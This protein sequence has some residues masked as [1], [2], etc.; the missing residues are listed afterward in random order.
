M[1]NFILYLIFSFVVSSSFS[2]TILFTE[3]FEN[4]PGSVQSSGTPGWATNSRLHVSGLNCDSSFVDTVGSVSYLQTNSFDCTGLFYVALSF[5]NICKV[6]FFD[7]GIIE[8]SIDG[9][10]TWVQLKDNNGNPGN[11]NNC[12][13][14]G[15]GY[16]RTQGSKFQEASYANWMA[17]V[18]TSPL[19]SWW[20]TE[21]FDIS[22]VAANQPD[23]KLRFKLEDM[24]GTGGNNRSGWYIDDIQIDAAICEPFPPIVNASFV[25]DKN[26]TCSAPATIQFTDLS[27]NAYSLLWDF[28]DG[29]FSIDSNPLH[30][31]ADTGTYTVTLIAIGPNLCSPSDTLVMTDYI[32][33]TNLGEPVAANCAPTTLNY[34]CNFGIN[35]FSFGSIINTSSGGING[36]QNYTCTFQTTAIAGSAVPIEIRTNATAAENVHVWI[37][38]NGDGD[39]SPDELVFSSLYTVA[40]H[41]GYVNTDPNV[42]LNTPLRMRVMSDESTIAIVNSCTP[43][44]KGEVEDYTIT[45]YENLNS[46]IANF[47]SNDTLVITGSTIHFQ[48]ISDHAPTSWTWSFPGG[49]PSTSN[50]QNPDIVYNSTGIFPVSL[51]VSNIFGIDSITKTAYIHVVNSINLCSGISHTNAPA[52]KLFDSGGIAGNYQNNENC[53]FL[54]DVD[55]ATSVTLTFNS[56]NLVSGDAIK[57]YSGLNSSGTLLLT[58]SGNQVPAP[59]TVPGKSLF[60]NFTSNSASVAF[61]FDINWTAAVGSSNPTI[62]SFSIDNSNPP[63]GVQVNFTDN[64]TNDP[65]SWQWDFG[66]GTFSNLQNPQHAFFTSGLQNIKLVA[67]NCFSTDT[68]IQTLLVQQAPVITAT[69]DSAFLTLGCG[70]TG[71]TQLTITNSGAG[72]LIIE[73]DSSKVNAIYDPVKILALNYGVSASVY[74][75]LIYELNQHFQNYSIEVTTTDSLQ[76]LQNALVDKDILILPPFNNGTTQVFTTLSPAILNFANNGGFVISCGTSSIAPI[77]NTG[78]FTLSSLINL[79]GN[80]LTVNQS[81]HPLADSVSSFIAPSPT[82]G[83]SGINNDFNNVL[84]YQ[85][86][87]IAGFRDFGLGKAIYTG[88]ANF[89][90]SSSQVFANA[91]RWSAKHIKNSIVQPDVFYD[92]LSFNQ[93][94]SINFNI[95]ATKLNAGVHTFPVTIKNNDPAQQNLVV[96]IVLTVTGLP[97]MILSDTCVNFGSHQLYI[98]FTDS[99]LISNMGCDTLNITSIYSSLP[100]FTSS[101]SSLNV[102]PYD[103]VWLHVTF[104]PDSN[105][106]FNGTLTLIN[107][108]QDT[109]ICLTGAGLVGPQMEF[110]PD[111]IFAS[112]VCGGQITVPFTIYNSG[113]LPLNFEINGSDTVDVLAL[114]YGVD[115]AN[116]YTNTFN[117]INQ[118]FTRYNRT[119]INT[120]SPTALQTALVGKE[121]F[122]LAEPESGTTSVF[123]TFAPVLQ[124]FVNN[125]GT[126]IL[127]GATSS[128]IAC[129]FNTGLLSGNYGGSIGGGQLNVSPITHLITD[130]IPPVFS[131]T[132]NTYS[133]AI[134]S[135]G[136]NQLISSLANNAVVGHVNYGLGQVIYNGF[137]YTLTNSSSVKLAGNIM[138]FAAKK[139]FGPGISV[140]PLIDTISSTD[141]TII[142]VTFDSNFFTAGSYSGYIN[143]FSNHYSGSL[144]SIPYV[145]TVTG[146]PNISLG[147]TCLNYGTTYIN[148]SVTDSVL[149]Y[150]TGCDSLVID[151]LLTS[152]PFSTQQLPFAIAPYD[153]AWIHVSSLT[154][155]AGVFNSTLT[156][157][158]NVTD[159]SICLNVT[160]TIPPTLASNTDTI[161]V[162]LGCS[163]IVDIPIT[164]YNTG[165]NPLIINSGK[166]P[167]RILAYTYGVDTINEY[168]NTLNSLNSFFDD[169]TLTETNTITPSVLQ[170]YLDD[171]DVLLF[172]KFEAGGGMVHLTLSNTITTNIASGKSA[173]FC[174]STYSNALSWFNTGLI[175]GTYLGIISNST[176]LTVNMNHPIA[177]GTTS[178]FYPINSTVSLD[179]V[180]PFVTDVMSAGTSN[181]VSTWPFGSGQVVYSG[182]DFTSTSTNTS[183]VISNSMKWL[184]QLKFK[185]SVSFTIENDTILPG[186]SLVYILSINSDSLAGGIHTANL[187]ISSNDPVTPNFNIPIVMHVTELPCSDFTYTFSSCNSTAIFFPESKN[188]ITSLVWSFGDG[189]TTSLAIPGYSYANSGTYLVSLVAC[190]SFGCDS[191]TK[192]I[193]IL[194]DPISQNCSPQTINTCCGMG[195]VNFSFS[196]INNI[197]QNAVAGYEKFTCLNA[198]QLTAGQTYPISIINGSSTNENVFAWIDYDNDGAFSSAEL[199]FTGLNNTYH[200]GLITIPNSP[201]LNTNL[202]MRIGSDNAN[203]P[204][205]SPCT[206]SQQGQFED[207]KVIIYPFASPVAQFSYSYIDTCDRIIEFTDSSSNGPTSWFWNFG[208]GTFATTQ[209]VQH[210]YSQP[211]M[212]NVM[213]VVTNSA[214]SNSITIPISVNELIA[215]ISVTGTLTP[216]SPIQFSSNSQGVSNWQWNFGDGNTSGFEFPTH[217]YLSGGTFTVTLTVTDSLGCLAYTDTTISIA[218][219]LGENS[220]LNSINVNPNPFTG[221]TE[222]SID[223]LSKT[224]IEISIYNTLGEAVFNQHGKLLTP[225]SYKYSI[226]VPTPGIYYLQVKTNEGTKN[227]RLVKIE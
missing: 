81:Q 50:I 116:E 123:T 173:F 20:Q 9:G 94:S 63:L 96:Y 206:N 207:Y 212:Y 99:V 10:L 196:N 47:T 135:P 186:D 118:T 66:D 12:E 153:S 150:N 178:P 39:L 129:I 148:T 74:Q 172:P 31:Y 160:S 219:G 134:T 170:S 188:P 211:G 136:F 37:D 15:T 183:K 89:T 92:T 24:D 214:G 154:T 113:Q 103:S 95:D 203:N 106:T 115:Y 167:L 51:T 42:I 33:V 124:T 209:T 7:G 140:T 155:T 179:I 13:Y 213:L 82:Y 61:G 159:T 165:D 130:S 26:Y 138:K 46:P 217:T 181:V 200:S 162:N 25:S 176:P 215:S 208:D 221:Y 143:I 16:F 55:C 133:A 220:S 84:T 97:E 100:Q 28:G 22:T 6:E 3:D 93:T 27:T 41:Q 122:Y 90:G 166:I 201:V 107:N 57:I 169:Y 223:I 197:S 60:I 205:L 168:Q 2:Q 87:S 139:Q 69:P 218:T 77:L 58:V 108:Q 190:N 174:G 32:Q 45:F 127:H 199:V 23:V 141:S 152:A 71:T 11:L 35:K 59:L 222:M 184:K 128:R 48:D 185:N 189:N 149:I 5:K 125:G 210:Q 19:N 151:S 117:S 132:T 191:V 18:I 98:P 156:I 52:G 105:I 177:Q 126:A 144:D 53:N 131:G 145:L 194:N 121:I 180:N 79:T 202:R 175:S 137:D 164:I 86:Y 75:N 68:V 78:L 56:L 110:S 49:S 114:T 104:N 119:E 224:E 111:T 83:L 43:P 21:F 182:F 29:T 54:I 147:D 17:G 73:L 4:P 70:T 161:Q 192:S 109:T 157:F 158:N 216:G 146:S 120:T 65:Q 225:G 102:S 76:T 198:A 80:I 204:L 64:S 85:N 101:V 193:T 36:Y 227:M 62:A 1:K 142:N 14:L 88:F 187:I 40:I 91:V 8:C 171:A 44:I 72:T 67:S 30:L 163:E 34:C 226:E 112:V 38:Y 195:I